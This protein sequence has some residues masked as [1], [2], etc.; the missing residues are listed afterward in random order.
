MYLMIQNPG[1]APIEGY[2]LLGVSTTRDCGV[3]GTIGQFGSGA[4]LAINTLL[5]A[6][7]KLVIYC[8]PTRLEFSTRDETIND[9]LVEKAIK[10]V[11]CHVGGT[12]GKTLDMGWCLDFGGI[13]WTDLAMGLREFVANAIDRTVRERGDFVPAMLSEDLRVTV[14]DEKSLRA[15]D[16]FTRV[17]IEVSPDVQRFYGELPRRFLHFC[18]NPSLVKESLLPKADRNLSG[19]K[20]AMIYKEGVL[21]R[22]VE[23]SDEPSLFDYNFHGNEL[24]LDESRNSSEYEVKAAAARLFR[25]AAVHH[26]VP[27]FTSLLALEHT[28]ESTFDS[29]YMAPGYPEPSAE[30]RLAWQSAWELAAGPNA[31]MCDAGFLHMCDF[32]EKKGLRAKQVRSASWVSA[33]SRVGIKTAGSVLDG[34]EKDGKKIVPPTDAAIVAVKTVWDWLDEINMTR[35]KQRPLVACFQD[36][37]EGG[38]ETMGYYANGAVYLK[39][40]IATS[41]HKYLLRTVLE[42]VSH[43]LSGA[44]DASRDFQSFLIQTIIAMK[45]GERRAEVPIGEPDEVLAA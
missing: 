28:Y 9:G 31:V 42:E 1:V 19:K 27:M 24:R 4:K 7:L 35:G 22:E 37:M 39:E 43:Y 17:F 45:T 12:R 41:G 20:T 14:V 32:V 21:V 5:R 38:V 44:A 10:R 11:V 25:R 2:T 33:A 26:M 40:D 15:K 3:S 8:G 18:T 6:R 16:G 30:Q 34:H 23:E 13:D 36:C 29:G